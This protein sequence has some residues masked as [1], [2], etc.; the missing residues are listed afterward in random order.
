M[1]IPVGR[2]ACAATVA[3][4][5]ATHNAAPIGRVMHVLRSAEGTEVEAAESPECTEVTR[6]NE[7]NGART[8]GSADR[9]ARLSPFV[10]RF[11]RCSVCELRSLR[12]FR[13][14]DLRLL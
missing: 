1:R 2:S 4:A 12:R 13:L 3:T 5:Q 7:G 14:L 9:R 6:S 11:L 8:E 10:L